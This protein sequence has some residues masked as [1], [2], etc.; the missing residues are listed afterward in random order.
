MGRH[1]DASDEIAA[2]DDLAV[3][4]GEDLERVDPV[5]PLEL[6]DPDVEDAGRVGDQVDP[7]L[8]RAADRQSGARH[9]RGEAEGRVILVQLAGLG[10]EDGDRVARVGGGQG[11]QVIGAEPAPLRPARTRDGQVARQDGADQARRSAPTRA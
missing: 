1:L 7:A 10:D 2:S 9:G 3:E 8:G 4:G 11:G 5:D 6:G